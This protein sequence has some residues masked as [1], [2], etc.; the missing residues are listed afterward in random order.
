MK[1]PSIALLAL[2]MFLLVSAC[3]RQEKPPPTSTSA[4]S[5]PAAGATSSMPEAAGPTGLPPCPGFVSAARM[6][7]DSQAGASVL[8]SSQ[9]VE[10]LLDSYAADLSADG[11]I[12]ETSLRQGRDHHLRFRQ[13]G[14][15]LHIQLGPADSP[16]GIS[17]LQLV[18][19][20]VAGAEEVRD[21]YDPEFEEAEPDVNQGSRE[22]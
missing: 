2:P 14:R 3:G 1:N 12:L 22:W 21:A 16:D 6:T 15:F 7:G 5:P 4:D 18:W 9:T 17:R 13:G 20:P 19:G 11:W 10:S 8:I